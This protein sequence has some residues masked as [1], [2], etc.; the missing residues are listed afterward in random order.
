MADPTPTQTTPH[1]KSRRA[2]LVAALVLVPVLGTTG[3]VAAQAHKSIEL[4]VD[5]ETRSLTTFAGSVSGAL[6]EAG[7]EVG[8]HD[9]VAPATDTALRDGSEIVVS[10]ARPVTVEI[11][12]EARVVWT[13]ARSTADV[14]AAAHES[15]RSL[16]VT[17]SRS[18]DGGRQAL[19]LP[20]VVDGDVIVEA[21]GTSQRVRVEGE[22]TIADALAAAGVEARPQDR[23]EVA[24]ADDG[25]VKLVVTRVDRAERTET[26]EIPFEI[27]ERSDDSLYEGETRVVQEGAPGERTR[28]Y[29]VLTVGGQEL[30]SSLRSEQVTTEPTERIVA[31]GTKERPAPAPVP[32]TRAPSSSSSAP[33]PSAPADQG[34]APT[35]GVWAALAQCESG[36]NPRA[37]SA[38]GLYYGL[39]QFSIGTWQSVGGTGLPSEASAAEQ[40]QRAQALQA[41]AGWGQWPHCA[42]KLGLL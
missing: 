40:T 6:E 32:A 38:N 11:D 7:I 12:G 2:A 25:T 30:H 42:A 29:A 4:E 14:L 9:V 27:V 10:T 34:S 19:G 13:T 8:E 39:Y 28:T 20:L 22:G 3:A 36:G 37:V 18:L 31:V 16:A 33:A 26:E 35:E 1:R 15:G 21:D 5:G 41:R 23:V 24:T 17:A